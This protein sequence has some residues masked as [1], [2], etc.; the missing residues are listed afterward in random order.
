[1]R[2][3]I[4]SVLIVFLVL[5][6]LV[7]WISK[8]RIVCKPELMDETNGIRTWVSCDKSGNRFYYRTD[9]DGKEL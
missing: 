3:T 6:G 4:I 1:M 9:R 5:L 2:D 8:V 7:F